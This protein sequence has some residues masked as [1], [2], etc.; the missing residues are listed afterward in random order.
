MSEPPVAQQP[1]SKPPMSA[2]EKYLLSVGER[3]LSTFVQAFLGVVLVSAWFTNGGLGESRVSILDKA[4][5]AGVAAVLS[6]IKNLAGGF[7]G[8][9]ATPSWLPQA[10][11]P[12]T[13][14]NTQDVT[15]LSPLPT[16][17]EGNGAGGNGSQQV[18]PQGPQE[19]MQAPP[20]PYIHR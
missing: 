8:N 12:G 16:T 10:A 4:A 14:P 13:T 15:V 5:V 17:A 11:D 9:S 18:S 7:V 20:T 2:K 6:L 19:T 3:V 1:V